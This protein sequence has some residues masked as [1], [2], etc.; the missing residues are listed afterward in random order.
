MGGGHADGHPVRPAL[1]AERAVLLSGQPGPGG[2]AVREGPGVRRPDGP[3]DGAGS[4]LRRGDH[5]AGD[6]PAGR[7]GRGR[8]D[9]GGGRGERGGERP[10]QRRGKRPV[11]AGGCG[12][13]RRPAGGGGAPA[14]GGGGGPAPE[15][16]GGGGHCRHR[17][18][19][20]RAGGVRLLRSGYAGTG[21]PAL[22]GGGLPGGPGRGGGP[23]P[24]NE[25]CGDGSIDVKGTEVNS[26][27]SLKIKH[28]RAFG[29]PSAGCLDTRIFLLREY[30]NRL[31]RRL[32]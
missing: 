22:R 15:G 9:R 7:A 4:V 3:G 14:P 5:H 30:I 27:N 25:A 16:A 12:G 28:F 24:Q 19:G 6:G 17:R 13:G 23:V 8:G 11:P 32:S 21:P 20:P 10:A 31:N 29:Q 26:V 1:P 18:Y 2:A